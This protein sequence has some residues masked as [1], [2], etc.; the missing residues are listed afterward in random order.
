[1]P[2]NMICINND[3][4][5]HNKWTDFYSDVLFSSFSPRETEI[6]II[7]SIDSETKSNTICQFYCT[8]KLKSGAI[9]IFY[10]R[11]SIIQGLSFCPVP[12][13]HT[14][15]FPSCT[16]YDQTRPGRSYGVHFFFGNDQD[17]SGTWFKWENSN[18]SYTY[19]FALFRICLWYLLVS[20]R[21]SGFTFLSPFRTRITVSPSPPRADRSFVWRFFEQCVLI[22]LIN[23]VLSFVNF[24]LT[25][26][27]FEWWKWNCSYE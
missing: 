16:T 15:M 17:R 27:P 9:N 1:M 12:D 2:T 7:D 26:F 21:Q 11:C 13:Q 23:Y 14:F 20:I 22:A 10:L 6:W 5:F 24:S 8:L 19:S 18:V 25:L 4:D 3:I